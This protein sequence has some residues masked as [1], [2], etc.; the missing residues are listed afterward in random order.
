[1]RGPYSTFPRGVQGCALVLLRFSTAFALFVQAAGHSPL[2]LL[3]SFVPM[4]L[5]TALLVLLAM[6]LC[7]GLFT[8]FAALTCAILQVTVL[9][10]TTGADNGALFL[11]VLNAFALTLLGPGQRSVDAYLFGPRILQNSGGGRHPS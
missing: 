10:T 4:G 3:A 6:L 9:A 7:A 11:P 8:P 1:M 2:A 5:A